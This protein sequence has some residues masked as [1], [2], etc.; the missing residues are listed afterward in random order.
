M[1]GNWSLN[2]KKKKK[3]LKEKL[4]YY[5]PGLGQNT[6]SSVS[7]GYCWKGEKTVTNVLEEKVRT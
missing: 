4:F 7:Q 2:Q 5:A 1:R 6:Y 3:K